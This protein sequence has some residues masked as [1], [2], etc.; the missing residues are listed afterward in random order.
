MYEQQATEMDREARAEI[1]KKMQ[2][3][4]Y[5]DSPYLV[6]M[7]DVIGEAFRSDR[8]ACLQPQ[9]DPGGVLLMQYGASNYTQHP[10][11]EGRR[12]LRRPDAAAPRR[13]PAAR[14]RA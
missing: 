7:Y 11:G 5:E 12:R 10:P 8:F 6:T 13:P 1:V 3:K 9:P 14:T 2:Q 4:L